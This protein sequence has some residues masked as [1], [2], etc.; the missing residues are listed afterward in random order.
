MIIHLKIEQQ[1]PTHLTFF[2]RATSLEAIL[3]LPFIEKILLNIMQ[4]KMPL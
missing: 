3:K 2:S 4:N 1:K